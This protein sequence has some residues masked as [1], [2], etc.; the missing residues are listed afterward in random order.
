MNTNDQNF[1]SIPR[2]QEEM[3]AIKDSISKKNTET[4]TQKAFKHNERV[5]KYRRIAKIMDTEEFAEFWKIIYEDMK[6]LIS[7]SVSQIKGSPASG[8]R[9]DPLGQLV[10]LNNIQG[11]LE[12]LESIAIQKKI[13]EEVA[14]EKIINVEELKEKLSKIN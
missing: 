2:T 11:G 10:Q 13:I 4:V 5:E 14:K 8:Q 9:Y 7:V 6:E 3:E 12:M 1:E